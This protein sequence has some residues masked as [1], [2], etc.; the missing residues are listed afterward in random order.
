MTEEPL[1]VIGIGHD[2]PAGLSHEALAHIA[3]ARVLVGGKRHLA[4]FPDWSG[5]TLVIDADL[6]RVVQQLK[7]TYRRA[8][9][10]LLA[11]G[12]PLF[13]GIGRVLTAHFPPEALLFLPQVS[14]VQLAFARI[15]TSW[16][17]AQVVSLHGRPL[18]A[19]LPALCSGAT[20]I[21][22][23]TDATNHPAAI[24]RFLLDHGGAHDLLWVCEEL[25]GP[26]ERVTQWTPQGIL[27]QSFSPL[28]VT[29]LLRQPVSSA[30]ANSALPLLGL[31]EPSMAHRA[32]M[33]TK[34]EIRLL[35]LC[36]LE[37]HPGEVFWDVGAGSGSVAVEAARLSSSLQVFAIEKSK[38][39]M[40]HIVHNVQTFAL[41][42]V[43]PIWGEAPEAFA[44]LPDPQAVFIGG[45]GGRLA[46]I[47]PAVVQRLMP[48]G[49]LVLN[50]ITLENFALGWELLRGQQLH[51]DATSVQLAHT[52]P[53]GTLHRFEADS[54]LFIVQARKI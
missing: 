33:I 52:R 22:L 51:V 43:Q 4:F 36:Y 50:C 15:K 27:E 49:R 37:L 23:L 1:V 39:A 11:S 13:Y 9:T 35:S 29:I 6:D 14:S 40:A 48:G 53:L 24:G 26:R 28:N 12:D 32:G 10:V 7:A 47:I 41:A 3:Q 54:P 19:L 45:S 31:P 42:N 16:H 38:D 8:K 25:G 2:G 5:E 20:K 30:T 44:S 18:P 46:D 34:R 17:D 21:A